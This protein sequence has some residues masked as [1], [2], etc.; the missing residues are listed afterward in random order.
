MRQRFYHSRTRRRGIAKSYIVDPAFLEELI[1]AF[2]VSADCVTSDSI[3]SS[4][5]RE[6]REAVFVTDSP[7]RRIL[8]RGMRAKASFW[9]TIATSATRRDFAERRVQGELPACPIMAWS[10]NFTRFWPEHADTVVNAPFNPAMFEITD[11]ACNKGE[12]G[13]AC[14]LPGLL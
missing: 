2:L 5:T 6:V 4:N 9:R 11:R 10:A 1:P 12:R 7:W 3:L 8:M 14:Q 13:L